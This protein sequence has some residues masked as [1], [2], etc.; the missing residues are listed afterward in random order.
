M[1][2]NT[3]S[4]KGRIKLEVIQRTIETLTLYVDKMGQQIE[5]GSKV[6]DNEQVLENIRG[7]SD[8]VHDLI[9]DYIL[10]E[11][12]RAELN[13]RETQQAFWQLAITYMGLLFGVVS[14]SVMA[15]WINAAS[16]FADR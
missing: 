16:S 13:Y 3:D 5:S 15:A 1:M 2:E 11:V 10:F 6:T 4:E 9:Q 14:F 12:N 8:L 7:V